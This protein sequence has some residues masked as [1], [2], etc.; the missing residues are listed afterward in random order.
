MDHSERKT[1]A[2]YIGSL[3]RGG[4]EHVMVNL[5]SFFCT[6]GYKVYLVTKLIE[7][8]EYEVPKGVTRILADIT[9]DEESDSRICNLLR[10]ISK[11]RNI[12]N[13]IK[14]DIIISFIKKNNL[15][16]IASSR[17][18]RIPVAI[19]I[20]SDPA[21]EL[22]GKLF[23]YLSFFMFGFAD[24]I[25]MQ[26]NRAVSFLP[27]R[28]QKKSV[29]L[30]NSVNACDLEIAISEERRK[31]IV[32]VG[33]IDD[34]KNQRMLIQ[35]FDEI[36]NDNPEWSLHFYGDGE[37]RKELEER[38]PQDR[39]VFHGHTEDVSKYINDASIFVL[40]SK[41]EG[42]PN[43]LIEAMCLGLACIATD[44]PCGGPA[45]LIENNKNGI[46]IP[47][48]DKKALVEQLTKLISDNNFREKLGNNAKYIAERFN[49]GI[50]NRQ[51]EDYIEKLIK[52]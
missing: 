16:A 51:W 2:F 24:G 35:A 31:E 46:L 13:E 23:R 29:V 3:T 50:V 20:R 30:P 47:V 19:S 28:L 17:G 18:L 1:I 26:T 44:C 9:Q 25:I 42:M 4:A 15:M 38:Y 48:D 37:L 10:R 7:E 40:P 8:P 49:P 43:A 22:Q 14:P 12:W 6:R 52:Q 36:K 5:A 32:C 45:D 11:L 34:N 39:I 33:R 27:D 41:R 21:R